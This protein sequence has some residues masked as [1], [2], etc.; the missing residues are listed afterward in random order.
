[1][2]VGIIGLDSTHTDFFCRL[3]SN[4]N[5]I[6]DLF[7]Y[8]ADEALLERRLSEYGGSRINPSKIGNEQKFDLIMILS[9]FGDEHSG[10]FVNYIN[11]SNYIFLD[12]PLAIN[13]KDALEVHSLAKLNNSSC[14]SHGV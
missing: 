5:C 7:F 4:N 9:R 12:K 8:D 1:M 2:L 13:F 14:H 3:I 10:H 6:K 11:S